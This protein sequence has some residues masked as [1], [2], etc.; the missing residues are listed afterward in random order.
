MNKVIIG[1]ININFLPAM[2]HQVKDVT[3]RN[4]YILVITE[5]KLDDIFPVSQS[6]V[7]RFIMPDILDRNRNGGSVI[8]Y[9]REDNQVRF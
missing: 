4:I 8:I 7:E 5:T 3:L 1:N 2:F 9:V 6:Y